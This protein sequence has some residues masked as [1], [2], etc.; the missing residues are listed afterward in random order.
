MVDLENSFYEELLNTICNI[1][2]EPQELHRYIVP[3]GS[4]ASLLSKVIS[5]NE[6]SF[7]DQ[8]ATDSS[9]NPP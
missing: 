1:T 8:L 7:F 4:S 2:Q 5:V 6:K 9:C 3:V